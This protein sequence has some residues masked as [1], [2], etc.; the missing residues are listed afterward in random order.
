[1]KTVP[2]Y[3]A[4]NRLS[5]LIAD[6]EAGASIEITRRGK[7]VARLVAIGEPRPADEDRGIEG[8]FALLARLRER[9]DLDGD[10][11]AIAREGLR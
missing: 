2:L 10:I 4:K 3:E 5:E 11:K 8:A 6:I 9:L 7:P 1:M